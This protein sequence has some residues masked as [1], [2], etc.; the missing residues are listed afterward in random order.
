MPFSLI[1]SPIGYSRKV[2]LSTYI[3]SDESDENYQEKIKHYVIYEID[4]NNKKILYRHFLMESDGKII[5]LFD[6]M[7]LDVINKQYNDKLNKVLANSNNNKFIN[8]LFGNRNSK[9]F[10]NNLN[11]NMIGNNNVAYKNTKKNRLF[12]GLEN[13]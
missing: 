12:S 2:V 8:G 11:L 1:L 10:E 9:N 3:E 4:N 6:Q 7:K 13:A 5:E